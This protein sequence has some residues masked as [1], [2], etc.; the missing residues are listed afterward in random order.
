[1]DIDDVS[2][3]SQWVQQLEQGRAV[4]DAAEKHK[5]ERPTKWKSRG[6]LVNEFTMQHM[7]AGAMKTMNMSMVSQS[8]IADPYPPSVAPLEILKKLFI[9]DMRLETQHRGCYTVLRVATPP[10][11]RTAIMAIVE[12]EKADGVLL[13][14]YQQE[15]ESDR[16]G[17]KVME[18]N[19]VCIVKE[20]YFKGTSDGGYGVRVDHLSDI[21]WLSSEDERVPFEWRPQI[22]E[23]EKTTEDLKEEG[24]AAFKT[25]NFEAAIQ[26]YTSAL[27]SSSTIEMSRTLKLN[28]SMANLKLRRYDEALTDATDDS[29]QSEKGL[30]RAAIALYELGRF[31][32]SHQAFGTL[33]S[34][35]PTSDTAKKEMIRTTQRLKEQQ[36]GDYN[37]TSMYQAAKKNPPC[38][39]HATFASNV[40]VRA[41]EGRGRGLFTTKDMVAGEILLCEKAFA[42]CSE[43]HSK[44]SILMHTRTKRAILGTQADL[45]TTIANKMFRNPSLGAAFTSLHH[46]DYESVDQ[47]EVDGIPIVDT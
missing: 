19:R 45:I 17:N 37:F 21:V 36:H 27:V 47:S 40:E 18:F 39:D 2:H 43:K 16:S 29:Q 41:S 25:G 7:A 35:Y 44:I 6:Q 22:T 11:T 38:L 14:L 13:S 5:G 33:L 3:I 46:G 23:L 15:S 26:S 31:Q 8:W 1:M 28:R 12:D 24:N 32:E 9:K 20:P 4:L 42:Y 34:R 10:S 30:Y